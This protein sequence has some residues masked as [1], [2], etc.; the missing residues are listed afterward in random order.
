ME[1][2][3]D[4]DTAEGLHCFAGASPPTAIRQ[5]FGML[6]SLPEHAIRALW[7]LLETILQEPDS[8]PAQLAQFAAQQHNVE[9]SR[10]LH[11]LHACDVL[12]RQAAA[13]NLSP[14]EFQADLESLGPGAAAPSQLLMPRFAAAMDW[15]RARILENT[16]ADHGKVVTDLDWRVEQLQASNHGA[17]LET[18]ILHLA[19]RYREGEERGVIRLQFT[20]VA[21][22]ALKTLLG[23]LGRE[24]GD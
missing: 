17:A 2:A 5:G 16:L 22:D 3:P 4:T 24:R 20:P 6:L 15:L 18:R 13:L 8:D 14:D 21:A 9:S 10:I 11:A 7:P 12:L 1:D 23:Q 19:L